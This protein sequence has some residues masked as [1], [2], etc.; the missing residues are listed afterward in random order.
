MHFSIKPPTI[1]RLTRIF[2]RGGVLLAGM[3]NGLNF[4][5][6]DDDEKSLE[7]SNKLYQRVVTFARMT[8]LQ[9]DRYGIV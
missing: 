8:R 2:K 3:D 5:F 6:D 7:I 9:A 4:L 1:L